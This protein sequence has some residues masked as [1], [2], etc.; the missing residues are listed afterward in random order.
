M[1]AP[2]SGADSFE[3]RDVGQWPSCRV[4]RFILGH[5]ASAK[6]P[7]DHLAAL[8]VKGHAPGDAWQARKIGRQVVLVDQWYARARAWRRTFERT[9]STTGPGFSGKRPARTCSAGQGR[10]DLRPVPSLSRTCGRTMLKKSVLPNPCLR[11]KE[12]SRR[13]CREISRGARSC[14]RR[15][16]LLPA[17]PGS[18]GK[19]RCSCRSPQGRFC[20]R[21]CRLIAALRTRERLGRKPWGQ[22]PRIVRPLPPRLSSR[23]GRSSYGP[24][25]MRC[26]P[27]ERLPCRLS[28]IPGGWAKLKRRGAVF[29]S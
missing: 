10:T 11:V 2:L 4:P 15:R 22:R 8:S 29:P 13:A 9:P 24:P 19:A 6:L 26:H 7:H 21:P 23:A 25:S 20:G 17:E 28:P 1:P 5:V 12:R 16:L 18:F 27:Q 14:L 3:G